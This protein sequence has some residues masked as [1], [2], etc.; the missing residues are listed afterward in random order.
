[1]KAVLADTGAL[2]AAVDTSDR[3]HQKVKQFLE[4]TSDLLM[5]PVTVMPEVCY[6]LNSHLGYYAEHQF[7]KSCVEGEIQVE[8]LIQEDL[9]RALQLMEQFSDANIGFV[10][11]SVAAVAERMK[12]DRILTTDR[13]HFSLFRS[14]RHR[15]FTL[16]P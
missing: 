7:V 11:A 12:I 16:L 14:S 6:L 9:F 4:E 15:S 10:D 2:Y 3:W 1:M 8:N 13:R 5:M